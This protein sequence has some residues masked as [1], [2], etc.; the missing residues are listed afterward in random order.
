MPTGALLLAL[1]AAVVHAAWNLLLAGAEDPRSAAVVQSIAS[2]VVAAPAAL[3]LWRVEDGAWPYLAASFVLQ[4]GYFSL[5]AAAYAEGELSL[6]YPLARGG[7]PL[8]VAAAAAIGIGGSVGAL[9]VVGILAIGAGVV[10]VRG[11]RGPWRGR[12]T[13]LAGA[14]A[15]CI[16]GYTIVDRYGVQHANPVTYLWIVLSGVAVAYTAAMVR[17]RGVASVRAAVRWQAVVA[18]VGGFGAYVMVLAALRLASAAPVAAVR[19]TSIVAAVALGG[20][21]LGER[22]GRA[23]LVG[24]IVVT[25]GTVFVATGCGTPGHDLMV[26]KRSGDLPGAQL[27]M[28]I[29]DDGFVVCNGERHEMASDLLID[30][31]EVERDLEPIADKNLTLPARANSV[32]RYRIET[33]QGTV[34]FADTSGGQ[35]EAFFRAALLVRRLAKEACGLPR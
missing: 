28:R 4:L 11:L 27:E 33:E 9:Q 29:A 2:V 23:R 20:L 35:P 21:I 10:A 15:A 7:A 16:A 8:L 18:G 34:A 19:E 32:L 5:L 17:T 22:V 6:V 12:D 3:L 25:L 26:V 31:R 14:T 13:L 1:G 30:A 24:A